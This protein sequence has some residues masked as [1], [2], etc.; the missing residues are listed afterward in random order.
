MNRIEFSRFGELDYTGAEALNTL[1]TNLT[2][3]GEGVRKIM[4][5]SCHSFEGKS[6]ITMNMMR[7][8]SKLGK[9]VVLVDADLRKSV[10]MSK[11]GG[12]VQ[13][14]AR[15]GL[16]HYLAGMCSMEDVLYETNLPGAYIVP[17]G[18]EVRN[19]LSLLSTPK[20]GQILDELAERF[21]FVLVDAPPVGMIIDAAEIAKSC[22]G[23]LLVVNYNAVGRRALIDVK[24]QIVRTGCQI[25][26]VVLNNVTFDSYSSKKYYYKN[27][28]HTYYES[29]DYYGPSKGDGRAKAKSGSAPAAKRAR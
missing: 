4:T 20:L 22:D 15:F 17:V 25:L 1:C 26:G 9:R 12:R 29:G 13:Q 21:D 6:F 24:Q 19:S 7:T 27:Y 11:Y 16:A 10:I 8:L 28:Y 5:T 3:S 23:V 14:G 18:R 2:F